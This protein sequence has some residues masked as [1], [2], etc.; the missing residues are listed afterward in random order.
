MI[1][2]REA[3]VWLN[4]LFVQNKQILKLI[5]YFGDIKE[6]FSCDRKEI[7]NSAILSEEKI[8]FIMSYR[9]EDK[10][11]K[12]FKEYENFGAHIITIFD[13]EYPKRLSN[14]DD[15]PAVLYVKGE[16][17]PQDELAFSIVGSR[18][19]T[20]YGKESCRY[21]ASDLA[22]N[23]ITIVSGMA[24]G[25]DTVAHKAALEVGGRTIAVLGTGLNVIY[26]KRNE[27]LYHE[28]SQ[29]GA[30][31][32]EF[33][34][35]TKG[36]PYNF[37]RR[38]RI[39]S[40]LGLGVLVVEA[41]EKSGSLI[42]AGIAGEQGR[43]VFAIPG[44]INSVYSRGANKLIQDGAKLVISPQ[45]IYNE[46]REFEEFTDD[47]KSKE[48]STDNLDLSDQEKSIVDILQLGEFSMDEIMDKTELDV[49]TTQM[50]ITK[51]ELL[52]IVKSTAAGKYMLK[53]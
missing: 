9:D 27:K 35:N 4:Y 8:D 1:N 49:Q 40:G 42:T 51:L 7:E 2:N 44:N 16:I 28:I 36:A 17:F 15:A 39:V 38:N 24:N 41:K 30:V 43:D 33:P 14:V 25:A 11:K 13:D 19:I 52:D 12:I 47:Y 34:A 37:P 45:D 10:I 32:S 48:V 50:L 22:Q 53:L 5:E 26:P 21:I 6:I 20:E 31:I 3:L 23:G 18:K 29:N 46:V